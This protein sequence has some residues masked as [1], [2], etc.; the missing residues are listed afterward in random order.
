VKN[1]YHDFLTLATRI[2]MYILYGNFMQ[3]ATRN[4][5]MEYH[6]NFLF[7]ALGTQEKVAEYLGYTNRHYRKI[8]IKIENG[9]KLPARIENLI[10]AKARELQ[11]AG[12]IH[13]VQ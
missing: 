10:Q 9:E 11:L 12:V 2:F 8:R 3:S 5:T 6:M 1:G 7:A 13:A 4:N